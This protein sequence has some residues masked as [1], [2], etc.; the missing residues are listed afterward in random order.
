MKFAIGIKLGMSQVFKEDG[1]VVPVTLVKIEPNIV[2]QVK[3]KDKDGYVGIQLGS[4]TKK[5]VTKP[6]KGH[7]KDL[8]FFRYLKEV[9]SLTLGDTEMKVGDSI[10]ASLFAE[11]DKV[12]VTG[13]S[14][15]KGFQGAVK[16]HGFSGMPA[17]HGAHHVLRHVGSIGQRFPQHT[18]KGMRGP[19]RMGGE[20][21]SVRGLTVVN[22]DAEKGIISLKGAVPG[23][24]GGTIYIY[25][26]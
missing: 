17:S 21:S 12:K 1:T 6:L 22:V 4:G 8:G 16:R 5:R 10:T 14:K 19:G 24:N 25:E 7:M 15:G 11:G 2:V 3:T 18:L 23:N 13:S 9:S 20:K 26:L